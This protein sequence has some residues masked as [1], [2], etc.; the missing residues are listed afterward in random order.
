M[1]YAIRKKS[2]WDAQFYGYEGPACISALLMPE[3]YCA[4]RGYVARLA[5]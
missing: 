2:R 3:K 5:S 1:K 4:A